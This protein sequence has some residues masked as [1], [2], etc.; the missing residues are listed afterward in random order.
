MKVQA[1]RNQYLRSIEDTGTLELGLIRITLL[2]G[3]NNSGKSTIIYALH[4]IQ[5][6][7]RLFAADATRLSN[8]R[9]T[10]TLNLERVD[11]RHWGRAADPPI[12][13]T[14]TLSTTGGSA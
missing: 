11:M 2:V 9:P 8:Q 13:S 7:G 14:A 1:V 12:I 3:K 10:V 4:A 5:G 6:S